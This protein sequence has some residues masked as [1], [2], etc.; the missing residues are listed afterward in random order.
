MGWG[1]GELL[2]LTA[3]PSTASLPWITRGLGVS[4]WE[5]VAGIPGLKR[6]TW[7]THQLITGELVRMKKLITGEL[8][9]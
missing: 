3:D 4:S 5:S 6:E 1:R 2:N 7:G 8:V 9:E